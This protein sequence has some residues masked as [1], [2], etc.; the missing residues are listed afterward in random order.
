[1]CIKPFVSNMFITVYYTS[2]CLLFPCFFYP[3]VFVLFLDVLDVPMVCFQSGR[4]PQL[5]LRLKKETAYVA[6]TQ[7]GQ[8]ESVPYAP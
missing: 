7:G 8:L 3:Y 1:M 2:L 6:E 5:A 4:P